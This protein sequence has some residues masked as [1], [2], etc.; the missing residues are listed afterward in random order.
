MHRAYHGG[1]LV[2]NWSSTEHLQEH[3]TKMLRLSLCCGMILLAVAIPVPAIS[4]MAAEHTPVQCKPSRA[5][6]LLRE[7]HSACTASRRGNTNDQSKV[8]LS[9]SG[10]KAVELPQLSLPSQ[11]RQLS[12]QRALHLLL[13]SQRGRDS[14]AVLPM[15]L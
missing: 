9:C 13:L 3:H 7:G 15:V 14:W 12:A 8:R 4:Q 6:F 10:R 2:Q 11:T 5:A 1:I